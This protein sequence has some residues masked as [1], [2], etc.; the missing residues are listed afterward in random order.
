MAIRFG[1]NVVMYALTGNYKTDRCMCR[2]CWSGWAIMEL[3]SYG[4]VFAPHVPD[5]LCSRWR[6]RRWSLLGFSL[7][8]R[9]RAAPGRAPSRLRDPAAALANPLIVHETREG[10]T[11]VV[12]LIIDRSQSQDG[13]ARAAHEADGRWPRC[14][15]S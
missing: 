12:A 4:I 6:S 13:R 14:A 5:A 7:W 8:R 2:R 15:R 9:A 3:G 11:D 1:I 10:L